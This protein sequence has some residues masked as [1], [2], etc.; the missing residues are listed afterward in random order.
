MDDAG[1]YPKLRL[2]YFLLLAR[3]YLAD[4]DKRAALAQVSTGDGDVWQPDFNAG[5]LGLRVAVLDR[6]GITALLSQP[7]RELRI[8]DVEVT[9]IAALVKSNPWLLK[10]ILGL[11]VG[12]NEAP[13]RI[14]GRLLS[15]VGVELECVRREGSRGDRQRVYRLVIPDDG[16]DEIFQVWLERDKARRDV[17]TNLIDLLLDVQ[18]VDTSVEQNLQLSG[19]SGTD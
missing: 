16:R 13:I 3:E 18:V 10:T 12:K 15:L 2:Y 9:A 6:L 14:V 8:S 1:L 4:R 7:E 5:M 17:S 19:R 11:T